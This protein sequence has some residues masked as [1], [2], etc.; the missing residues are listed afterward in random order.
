MTFNLEK[1]WQGDANLSSV[2]AAMSYMLERSQNTLDIGPRKYGYNKVRFAKDMLGYYCASPAFHGLTYWT[3]GTPVH[4]YDTTNTLGFSDYLLYS[5]FRKDWRFEIPSHYKSTIK[6]YL[7][8][9]F[10]NAADH[11]G[12]GEPVFISS[13]FKGGYLKFTIADCG[14]GFLGAINKV[15][16]EVVT[17]KQAISWALSGK[18]VKGLDR[19]RTLKRLGDYCLANGGSLIVVSGNY[20]VKYGRHLEHEYMKLSAPFRGVIINL[21]IKVYKQKFSE[22]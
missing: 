22:E 18:S 17:D 6:K 12:N 2:C 16:D 7:K 13:S 14:K 1:A 8:E 5:A 4:I 9:L 11:M 19:S 3:G 10:Q 20:S 21:S 15:D